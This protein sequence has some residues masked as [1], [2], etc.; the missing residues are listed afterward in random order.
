[1]K[2]LSGESVLAGDVVRVVFQS[3]AVEARVKAVLVPG[4]SEAL[5]WNA[6]EGGVMVESKET[7]LI[8]W[9]APDEDMKFVCRSS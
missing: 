2:Y 7:G 3:S 1:L 4:S 6:P 5:Q 8:L 9:R